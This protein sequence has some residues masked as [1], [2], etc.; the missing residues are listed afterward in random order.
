M[1]SPTRFLTVRRGCGEGTGILPSVEMASR[2]RCLSAGQAR[3]A[4]NA[5]PSW[6]DGWRHPLT[7]HVM[8]SIA[9]GVLGV[10][11][12]RS[13]AAQATAGQQRPTAAVWLVRVGG[14]LAVPA[15][16]SGCEE[17]WPG[18]ELL[19]GLARASDR[20][21]MIGVQAT[22]VWLPGPEG[23]LDRFHLTADA[24]WALGVRGPFVRF[25]IGP[26][27]ITQVVRDPAPRGRPPGDALVAV[28]TVLCL[29]FAGGLGNRWRLGGKTS[30]TNEVGATIFRTSRRTSLLASV[31]VTVER[32]LGSGP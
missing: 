23:R 22:A 11:L 31:V 8:L 32:S 9:C 4:G 30:L 16:C 26:G 6:S 15:T 14:G 3:S 18:Y 29:G 5:E 17:R 1:R 25:G 27:V 24:V 19:A 2:S 28:E 10:L 12:P 13:L 21:P 20:R 7:R